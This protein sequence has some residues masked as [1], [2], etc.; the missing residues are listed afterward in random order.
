MTLIKLLNIHGRLN[1]NSVDPESRASQICFDS[2]AVKAGSVYVAIRGTQSDGHKYLSQAIDQ[3]AI[4]LVVEDATLI[5]KSF[6][7]VICE[8]LDARLALQKLSHIFYGSPGDQLTS[9]A[10]TGT[11]GKTSVSYI[12]EYLLSLYGQSCGVIGTIDHHL[13]DQKW[14]SELTTPD[15]I[16]L[17]KRLKD[18]VNMGAAAFVIEASSHA[19]KQNRIQQG[20]DLC[21]F[22]N[23]SRDHLD[24]HKTMADYLQSKALL[25][26]A[27]MLKEGDDCFAVINIDDQ[28]AKTLIDKVEGRQ[29][30]TY[31]RDVRAQFQFKILNEDLSGYR[32]QLSDRQ[33]NVWTVESPLIGEHNVYNVVACLVSLQ[34]LGYNLAEATAKFKN[35]Q[36]IPGRLQ[37]YCSKSGVYGFVDYAHTPD[38][39]EKVL[40]SL[41]RLKAKTNKL[42]TVFGC[43]GDRDSGKRPLMGQTAFDYSDEVIVTSDNPRS[44]N[45]EKIIADVLN[46]NQGSSK[47]IHKQVSR[48]KAIEQ[49]VTMAQPGDVVLVAGKGH[50]AYQIIGDKRNHFDDFSHLVDIMNL[51]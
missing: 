3:G 11:N 10:V 17:Q 41:K 1:W 19:L 48:K 35:F 26:K 25:F 18:F 28:S 7:G 36:G 32:F 34:A 37:S 47:K 49:A 42:I 38:A 30:L 40:L 50:E 21:I 23:L 5:P 20:F 22:T 14:E 16:T 2:R 8:V 29:I 46:F 31:G 27:D 24:Y 33:E 9:I 39:L 6:Q 44:E 12:L 45:P 15:P 4:V 51:V 13:N 43:G